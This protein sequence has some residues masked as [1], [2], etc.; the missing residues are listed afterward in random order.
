MLRLPPTTISLT[1]TEVKDFERRRRFKNYL[2][3]GNDFKQLPIRPKPQSL[4]Q[5]SHESDVCIEQP[6][7]ALT[8][9]P[10][11]AV[12]SD[13]NLKLL[14]CPPHGQ[15]RSM[16]SFEGVDFQAS[17]SSRSRLSSSSAVSQMGENVLPLLNL[18]PPFSTERRV[19]S[20]AQSLPSTRAISQTHVARDGVNRG[21]P[22]TPERSSSLRRDIQSSPNQT[23]QS[24]SSRTRLF[25][26]AARFVESIVHPSR[27][28]VRSPVSPTPST[29]SAQSAD[30][31]TGSDGARSVSTVIDIPSFRVY[32]DSLPAASQPQTPLNLP[33]AR[34]RSRLHEPFTAPVQRVSRQPARR[35]GSRDG[36]SNS[37]SPS[38]LTTP[39]FR[40]LYGGR[41][42]SSEA[43]F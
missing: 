33:E 41:E 10:I 15:P 20:D 39:G 19:V 2:A 42:N 8:S 18:P 38:G 34:H 6:H 1:I 36:P 31:G 26:S 16:R 11:K 43:S 13:D 30:S 4:T 9:R 25:S 32:N 14:P 17:S 27:H 21:P 40:G 23:P 22:V 3:K 37:G 7:R 29:P 28:D 24:D 12:E 35:P 5:T